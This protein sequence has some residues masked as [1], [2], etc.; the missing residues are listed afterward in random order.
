MTRDLLL[1]SRGQTHRRSYGMNLYANT[2]VCR[3]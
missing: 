1:H 2:V 3:G